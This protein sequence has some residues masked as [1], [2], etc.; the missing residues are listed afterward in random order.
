MKII[1]KVSFNIASY[2]YILSGQKL[3]KKRPKMV[4]FGE[5]L[6]I[7]SLR[8]NSVT[9]HLPSKRDKMEL[10]GSQMTWPLNWLKATSSCPSRLVASSHCLGFKLVSLE[11][12]KLWKQNVT[13]FENIWKSR[14][15]RYILS[16]QKFIKSVIKGQF[17]RVFWEPEAWGKKVL[18]DRSVSIGQK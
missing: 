8:S 14:E 15:V 2:V 13:V 5:F 16:G 1:E 17:W 12:Y 7:W 11:D 10:G 18:P 9:R 3:I 6:K 4:H